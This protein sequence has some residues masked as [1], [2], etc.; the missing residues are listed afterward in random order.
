MHDNVKYSRLV[1]LAELQ[2]S[3]LLP[4]QWIPTSPDLVPQVFDSDT[5]RKHVSSAGQGQVAL[6]DYER[7]LRI[8]TSLRIVSLCRNVC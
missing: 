5:R 3:A 4:F 7:M 1:P 6:P 8:G 2:G